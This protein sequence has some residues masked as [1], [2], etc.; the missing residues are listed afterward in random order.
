MARNALSKIRGIKAPDWLALKQLVLVLVGGCLL[1]ASGCL[2]QGRVFALGMLPALLVTGMGFLPQGF[3]LGMGGL[4]D[5]LGL[6]V[7]L[8]PVG[9]FLSWRQAVGLVRLPCGLANVACLGFGGL[10]ILH[11]LL[12]RIL[13]SRLIR[14]MGGLPILTNRLLIQG[15]CQSQ[16]ACNQRQAHG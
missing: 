1:F 7:R 16:C 11:D 4:T 6:L 8:L 13:A 12:M 5:L 9:L 14:L 10:A 3:V 15:V 2:S